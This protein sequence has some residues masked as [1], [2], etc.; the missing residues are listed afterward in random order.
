MTPVHTHTPQIS[1]SLMKAYT[2]QLSPSLMKAYTPQMSPS[3][4]YEAV[5]HTQ[6]QQIPPIQNFQSNFAAFP[7]SF[8]SFLTNCQPAA[9][10][11]GLFYF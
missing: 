11:G 2:P 1:P 5:Q 3:L 7:P 6:T 10:Q 4:K 9:E 8:T